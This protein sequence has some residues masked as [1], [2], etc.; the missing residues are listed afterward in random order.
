NHE[1][2]INP[3]PLPS[4]FPFV[5]VPVYLVLAL[6]AGIVLKRKPDEESSTAAPETE[7]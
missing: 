5:D 1:P 6:V 2:L 3:P 4:W 7:K